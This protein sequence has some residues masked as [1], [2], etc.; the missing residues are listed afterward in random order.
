MSGGADSTALLLAL[1]S[2]ANELDLE[3]LAAHLHHGLRGKD[4]DRDLDHV[5]ALC[6]RLGVPLIAARWDTRERMRRRGLSGEAG[7]RVLRREFLL[8]AKRS[9]N[10]AA[11]AT[12]HTADDQLETL[13]MRL[14]RGAGLPGLSGMRPRS[15]VW[16]KP[17]LEATRA[18]VEADL[19]LAGG[20]W[21]EDASNSD[22]RYLRNRVRHL[23]LPALMR[24]FGAGASRASLARTVSASADE[25]R[26]AE[27]ALAGAARRLIAR[28]GGTDER[29]VWIPRPALARLPRALALAVLRRLWRASGARG[30]GL[31][32]RH[33][34]ALEAL[35]C[36]GGARAR[37]G[38]PAGRYAVCRGE[39]ISIERGQAAEPR[40]A[41]P[42]ATSV[43][44][45]VR[46]RIARGGV[47]LAMP[48]W[49]ESGGRKGRPHGSTRLTEEDR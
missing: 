11:I 10:A 25:I 43:T 7:L 5:R 4:A 2:L 15:G 18:D 39:R 14:M 6:Q 12:A 31:T 24:A 23:V 9:A 28:A 38:L 48:R 29:G 41:A 26:E 32:R 8:A 36:A 45:A 17:M 33:L 19:S 46:G 37:V 42:R 27:R 20:A 21:R 47:K 44:P 34:Q 35:V 30:V 49:R 40:A 3:I 16:I 22:P 13:L 1:R